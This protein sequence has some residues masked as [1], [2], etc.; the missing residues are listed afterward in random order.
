MNLWWN[1]VD[2]FMAGV[3]GMHYR[4]PV[5]QQHWRWNALTGNWEIFVFVDGQWRLK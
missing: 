3:S 2:R 4:K 1:M 5:P